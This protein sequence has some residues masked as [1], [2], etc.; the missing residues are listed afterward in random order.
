M[1]NIFMLSCKRS[2]SNPKLQ[3]WKSLQMIPRPQ[4]SGLDLQA[5]VGNAESHWGNL[6][7][8]EPSSLPSTHPRGPHLQGEDNTGCWKEP[9]CSARRKEWAE[10]GSTLGSHTRRT[11]ALDIRDLRSCCT[12]IKR[13]HLLWT[14][15]LF[16]SSIPNNDVSKYGTASQVW[17]PTNQTGWQGHSS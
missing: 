17:A 4:R 10:P 13:H 2:W 8:L 7:Y 6:G 14:L 5:S 11:L 3:I 9:W 16:G 15:K 12:Q 1:Q